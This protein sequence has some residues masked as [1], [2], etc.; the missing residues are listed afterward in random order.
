MESVFTLFQDQAMQ[1]LNGVQEEEVI[2]EQETLRIL[3]LVVIILLVVVQDFLHY[4]FGEIFVNYF[5][6]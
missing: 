1:P 5:L 6:I 3:V 2:K 4:C